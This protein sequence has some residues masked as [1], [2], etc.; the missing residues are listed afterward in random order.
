VNTGLG[1]VS[2]WELTTTDQ[3]YGLLY[4]EYIVEPNSPHNF[5]NNTYLGIY[6]FNS[7]VR[8]L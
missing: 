6:Y 8:V 7:G 2:A 3:C 5:R 1:L 4:C